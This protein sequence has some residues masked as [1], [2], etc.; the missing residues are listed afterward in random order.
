MSDIDI[1]N[2]SRK[3]KLD[4]AVDLKTTTD[5]RPRYLLSVPANSNKLSGIS[6]T[7]ED[8]NIDFIIGDDFNAFR[9]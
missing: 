2:L 8:K 6:G 7:L 5:Y 9:P 4:I 1:A 3:L